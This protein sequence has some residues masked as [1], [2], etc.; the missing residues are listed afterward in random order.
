MIS[1]FFRGS[2]LMNN[3]ITINTDEGQTALKIKEDGKILDLVSEVDPILQ[4]PT[5]EFVFDVEG[6]EKA[7]EL[8]KNLMA[9]LKKYQAYGLAANQCG[10]PYSVFA[11]GG[12]KD[13]FVFFNP[14][15][16]SVAKEECMIQEGCLSFPAL[17]LN[18]SRPKS[19]KMEYQDEEG[20]HKTVEFDGLTARTVLH[21]YDHLQGITFLE[22]TKPLALKTG[23]K[24][25]DKQFRKYARFIS[26]QSKLASE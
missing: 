23:I 12:G 13:Y 22:R 5:K 14:K 9:T 25:R 18:I 21:E 15:I 20:N 11:V 17:I 16:V 1:L 10:I 2:I 7:K 19:I 3:I 4:E 26:A 8:A 6:K 24:K